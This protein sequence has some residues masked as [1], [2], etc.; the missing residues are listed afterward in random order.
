MVNN[1]ID[2]RSHACD[3]LHCQSVIFG[4]AAGHVWVIDS[5]QMSVFSD[6]HGSQKIPTFVQ[7]LNVLHLVLAHVLMFSYLFTDT[8]QMYRT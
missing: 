3:L 1:Q 6:F 4:N 5:A 7:S 8:L 2:L